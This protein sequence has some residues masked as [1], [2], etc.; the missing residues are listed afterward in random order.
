[1]QERI[2]APVSRVGWPRMILIIGRKEDEHVPYVAEK[3]AARG[4]E[5]FWF[6]AEL[7][8][9]AAAISVEYDR[10]GF[11][12]RVLD[13]RQQELDLAQVTA[14]WNREGTFPDPEAALQGEQR[15]WTG[16]SCS[17]FLADLWECLDCLWLPNRPVVERDALVFGEPP[18]A[19]SIFQP[20]GWRAPSCYNKLH[21]LAVA[22]RL[23]FTVPRTLVTNSPE[24]FLRFYEECRGQVISKNSTRL[25][26]RRDDELRMAFTNPVQR[27]DIAGYKAI[28]HA[29]VVFQEEVPKKL[30][31]RVTVV[32][33]KVFPAAIQS[34]RSFRL[35]HDWRH[36]HDFGE[37]KYYS[38]YALPPKVE[39]LCVRLLEALGICFGA[40]DL[41]VTPED[42]YVFLEVNPNGQWQWTESYADLPIADAIADLLIRG[43]IETHA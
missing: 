36:Y 18:D 25:K 6:Q 23:G 11:P 22:G 31:L 14:V 39:A 12:R 13:Y 38:A 10:L 2:G 15:W 34:Q 41:I 20:L 30:E 26:I 35:Q 7:F 43:A 8:P 19:R 9:S 27:R 17:R 24:R 29:P 33:N 21:Q 5:Y 3:L 42:D 28:R 16:E 1:M 40:L 32:G 4:A 37:S